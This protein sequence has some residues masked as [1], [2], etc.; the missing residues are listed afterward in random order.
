MADLASELEAIAFR[1]RRAGEDELLRELT[2][3][4]RDAVRPV[5][6][7]IR[8]G[9]DQH[10][11]DHYAD[12]LNADLDIKIIAR[13]GG[14]A[15]VDSAALAVYAQTRSGNRKLKRLESGLI[16]HPLFGDREHWYTQEGRPGGGPGMHPG[17]FSGPCEAAAPRVRDALEKAL[18]DVAARASGTG[19]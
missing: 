17:W 3:A 6:D 4:M 14:S 12:E 13:P 8:A 2:A 15:T 11:P 1:L 7:Q 18:R 10:M 16:T 5:P 19:A 9:L